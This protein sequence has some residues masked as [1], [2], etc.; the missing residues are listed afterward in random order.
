VSTLLFDLGNTRLKF[1][2]LHDDGRLGAV[3]AIAH[4]GVSLPAGWEAGLPARFEAAVLTSV[5]APVLRVALLDALCAR[6]SRI[7]IARTT[8]RCGALRIAY[9]QPES[10]GADRF[11]AM[12]GARARGPGPWLV[13]GIGTAITID[14][15]DADGRH[16]GGRIA[17]S[18]A[19]M[20]EALHA[21]A[22]QLPEHGG[23]FADFA[24]NTPGALRSGCDGAALALI[25][26]AR[27]DAGARLG[28]APG[29]LLHGGG[30]D[31]LAD[32]AALDATRAPALVLEGL[33]AWAR[34]PA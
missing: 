23:A 33:A 6:C 20:R 1:A 2:A 31:A 16:H 32:T 26:Q 27:R 10:L 15:V 9:P 25:A 24:D 14:L 3:A 19:L 7:S 28:T 5:A 21:R 4:D 12:L 17:P 13:V 30:A 34:M 29:L 8:A 11:L 22:A 18:P